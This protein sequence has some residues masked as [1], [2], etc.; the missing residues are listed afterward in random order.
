MR[1]D[2]AEIAS[3][4]ATS[5]RATSPQASSAQAANG[6]TRP[7]KQSADAQ[8]AKK[9]CEEFESI[10]IYQMLSTMRRAFKSGDDSDSGFGGDIFKSMM[11]EQLSVAMAKAGGIGLSKL[12][13]QGLGLDGAEERPLRRVVEKLKPIFQPIL[14]RKSIAS[15]QSVATHSGAKLKPF[16]ATIRAAA[17]VF[18]LNSDLIRAVIMQESGGNARAVSEKGAK[19]LMQLMDSTAQE[20]GVTNPFDPVQNIFGGARLLARLLRTFEGNLELA[21]ASYNAGIGTVRKH[22][23]MPPFKETQE[24]V[25][26]VSD[27]LE[28]L[29]A[30]GRNAP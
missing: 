24:Y 10:L 16:D 4:Q 3:A 11:D 19:G 7:S 23:G 25:K 9:A 8:R 5:L 30:Q 26:R 14:G 21:L 29:G 12:M 18:G 22:G 1:I 28:S 20:L 17:K 6:S 13:E 15:K 2:A 27:S